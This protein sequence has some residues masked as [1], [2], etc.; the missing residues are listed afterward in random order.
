MLEF[1]YMGGHWFFVWT[2]YGISIAVLVL[3][4]WLP[5]LRLRRLLRNLPNNRDLNT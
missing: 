4:F 3:M 2:S 1:L 5:V